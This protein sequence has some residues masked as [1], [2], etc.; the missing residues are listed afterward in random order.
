[1]WKVVVPSVERHTSLGDPWS[2]LQSD[3]LAILGLAGELTATAVE[4]KVRES[5]GPDISELIPRRSGWVVV[6]EIMGSH[7]LLDRSLGNRCRCA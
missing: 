2:P 7:A 3:I 6:D 5:F 4:G 1:M